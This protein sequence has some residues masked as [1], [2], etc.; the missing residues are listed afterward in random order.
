MGGAGN[1]Q[2][3]WD[4]LRVNP[5]PWWKSIVF[6]SG[7]P[8]LVFLAW[9]W[10]D[11]NRHFRSVIYYRK[12]LIHLLHGEGAV[13][14]SVV[15]DGPAAVSSIKPPVVGIYPDGNSPYRPSPTWFPSPSFES[16]GDEGRG[17]GTDTHVVIPY[18]MLT[19]GHLLFWAGLMEIRRR[20]IRR[21]M[22]RSFED[23]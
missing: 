17:I 13:S 23:A 12:P 1:R 2:R 9:A 14:L 11:S 4:S 7:V 15:E 19:M 5:R 16:V 18:W 10:C 3:V 20:W 21:R 8:G 6:W 22:I